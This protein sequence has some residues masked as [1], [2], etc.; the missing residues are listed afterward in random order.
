[1]M[2]ALLIAPFVEFE[3]MRRAL[4]GTAA[5]AVGCGPMG[6]FLM[7]RRMSL[8]GDAMAH[9]ILPGAAIGFLIAGLS[10]PAMTIGGLA[11]GVLVAISSGLVTRAT[12]LKEDASLAAFYLLSLA[13]GVTIVSL[14]GSNIDLLHVLFGTVLALDD[15]TLLLLA[16]IA[17]LTLLTLAVLYRPLVMECVDPTFLRSISRAG[18]PTHLVFLGLVVLNLV[19]GFH[20]LGTLLAVGLMM[21]PAVAAR[22]W[23]SDIT[24]MTLAA[25]AIAMASGA[26]GLL[27]SFH[28]GLPAGPS[29]I[30]VAG[31]AYLLSLVLGPEDGLVWLAR[32]GRHLEA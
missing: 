18:A 23:T 31:A 16:G 25:T 21:L 4:V 7:L 12:A 30:L 6:V 14:R 10:L 1:M 13:L 9:A 26:V 22:F 28:A 32:P 29:I 15:P 11:A 24:L 2:Y 27:I 17:S 19:G 20:A 3:F 8:M 5:I